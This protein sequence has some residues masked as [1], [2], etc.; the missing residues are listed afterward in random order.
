VIDERAIRRAALRAVA[1]Q[2][3][4]PVDKLAKAIVVYSAAVAAAL[5][6]ARKTTTA[7]E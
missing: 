2:M 3:D 5:K 6:E 1:E 4:I 7:R